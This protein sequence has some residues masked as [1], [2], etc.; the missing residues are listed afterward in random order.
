MVDQEAEA[1]PAVGSL[2]VAG[3]PIIGPVAAVPRIM[4]VLF[5]NVSI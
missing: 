3:C 2:P 1:W 5:M 4:G